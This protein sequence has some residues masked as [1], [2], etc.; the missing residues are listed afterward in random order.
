MNR[1]RGGT[2]GMLR[3]LARL[4]RDQDGLIEQI[5]G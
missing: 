5:M 4:L 1:Y 2:R 3:E